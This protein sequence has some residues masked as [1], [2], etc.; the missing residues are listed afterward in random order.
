[1]PAIPAF[2]IGQ[3]SVVKMM[4]W[5]LV[6]AVALPVLLAGAVLASCNKTPATG[7]SATASAPAPA[8]APAATKP[9]IAGTV[10]TFD[11]Q[12]SETIP[13]TPMMTYAVTFDLKSDPGQSFAPYN[14]TS[15]AMPMMT[16][17]FEVYLGEGTY[18][19]DTG[20]P[21]MTR[22][23]NPARV[24]RVSVANLPDGAV[25]VVDGKTVWSGPKLKSLREISLGKGFLNRTWKGQIS[26]PAVCE[27][28]KDATMAALAADPSKVGCPL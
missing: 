14:E 4:K 15:P 1:L 27:P 9:E 11:G 16:D 20:Q 2:P 19:F 17:G 6:P 24:T 26:Q 13:V 10:I 25:L 5:N 21:T 18:E 23:G 8:A 28:P 7:P 3:S 12:K 22:A